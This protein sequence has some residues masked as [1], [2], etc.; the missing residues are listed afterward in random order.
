MLPGATKDYQWWDRWFLGLAQ[1]ISTA[2]KDPSTKVGAV[3]VDK[4]RIIRGIGYNG[5][6][7][8]VKDTPARYADREL[9]Y[10]LVVHAEVNALLNAT[11]SVQD[12]SIYVWPTLMVPAVCPECCKAVIQSGIKRVVGWKG[13]TQERWQDMAH[14]SEMM[15]REAGVSIFQIPKPSE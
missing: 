9:K 15:L 4:N 12:C 2:S 5:F 11:G 13:E 14:I 10:K 8:G 7:R 3:I 1:Y 6:P